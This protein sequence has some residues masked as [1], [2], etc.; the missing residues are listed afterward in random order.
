MMK[1]YHYLVSGL[2]ELSPDQEKLED[3]NSFIEDVSE[4]LTNEDRELFDHLRL[5]IDTL[6][7]INNEN[8]VPFG[9]F[10]SEEID[11]AT[12]NYLDFPEFIGSFI[13]DKLDPLHLPNLYREELSKFK[14][15]FI[16][17]YITFSYQLRFLVILLNCKKYGMDIEKQLIPFDDFTQELVAGHIP[18]EYWVQEVTTI[19]SEPDF[20]KRERTFLKI[21]WN[22]ID[23][24]LRFEY[25]TLN[26]ILAHFIKLIE[27]NNI[28]KLNK[29]VGENVFNDKID[30]ITKNVSRRIDSENW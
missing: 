10:S 7:I 11:N 1:E 8:F 21:K 20:I 18:N 25:F 16:R 14:N 17:D 23:E 3:I 29:K 5:E 4:G 12:K 22:F 30:L 27:L 15:S 19:F 13:E 2:V 6:N 24:Y 26:I 28:I 9:L